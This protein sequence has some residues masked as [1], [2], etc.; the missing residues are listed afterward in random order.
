MSNTQEVIDSHQKL[1]TIE[2]ANYLGVAT[3]T[4]EQWRHRGQGPVFYKFGRSVRYR[5]SDLL[6]FEADSVRNKQSASSE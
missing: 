4:L 5:L 3:A 1:T 2:A 6:K